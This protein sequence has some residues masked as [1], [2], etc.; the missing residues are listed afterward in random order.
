MEKSNRPRLSSYILLFLPPVFWSSNFIVGK[1]LVGIVPPWTL[2]TGR[3]TVSALILLPALLYRKEW[4]PR[5]IW[6]PLIL[7]SITGVFAF[8]AVLYIGLR[9]TSA[10]NA[11]LVNATTPVTTALIAWLVI[12]E[13]ITRRRV[14]GIL[15]S[16]TG[17]GW[18]VSRGS[19]ET[20]LSLSFNVG[21][22]IVFFATSLWGFYM[23]MAKPMM[24]RLSPLALTSITTII[25]TLFLLPAAAIEL[26]AQPADLWRSEVI[27]AFLYLGIFP[28]FLSFLL[29]NRSIQTFGPGRASLAYNTLPL[30]AV[31]LAG[32]FLD[33][34]LRVY[35]IV[36]GI[37]II[38]GV[39]IGTRD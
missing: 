32:I 26:R 18:I 36:G 21:D 20:L 25:G 27:L 14:A 9:H 11:T 34:A 38:V 30:F 17:I 6:L 19:L 3:F 1:A 7:M 8:N 33:E 29:W 37:V 35:Q 23:V 13:E 24:R 12:G 15:L 4:P 5:E 16:F 22:V 28:S 10:I 2:N 39:L 31:I